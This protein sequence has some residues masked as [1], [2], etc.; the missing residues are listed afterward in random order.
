[1]VSHSTDWTIH[2]VKE[3][4]P[5]RVDGRKM[6]TVFKRETYLFSLGKIREK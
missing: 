3:I 6:R 5:N 2:E 1:M 4:N